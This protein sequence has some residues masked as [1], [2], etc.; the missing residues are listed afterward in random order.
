MDSLNP[1][2]RQ[3]VNA[4]EGPVL[5]LAG[6][7]TGK[8][9][10]VTCRIAHMIENGIQGRNLLAVTFTNK[11]ANEMRER[12][13]QMVDKKSARAM[14]ISTFHSLCTRILRED[15]GRLGYKENF[16]IYAGSDQ[17]GLLRQLIVRHGGRKEKLDPA[18]VLSVISASRN[19]GLGFDGIKDSL[20][21]NIAI[22]YQRELVAQNAVDFDDLLILA[23]KLLAENPDVRR[24]WQS[25]F[26][27]ITVD[28]FQDTNSLQMRLLKH[29]VGP[30]HN[31]CVVGDDDQSIYGWRG[32]QISNILDFESFFPN[33]TVIRLEENYRCTAPI[34]DVANALIRHNVGRREKTLHAHRGSGVPVRLISMP[35]DAEEAEFIIEDIESIRQKKNRNWEDFAILFRANAQSRILEQTLREH[36]IPYKM[37]GTKSFFDRRE[38]KDIIAYLGLIDNPQADLHLLRVLNTPPRGISDTTAR[39][40]IEWSR[41]HNQ[42]VWDALQDSNFLGSFSIRTQNSIRQFIQLIQ[43]YRQLFIASQQ[44]YSDLLEEFIEKTKYSDYMCRCCKTENE[45]QKRLISIG[46]IKADLH[47]YWEPG[48]QLTDFLSNLSL[49][50]DDDE[51]DDIESKPGVC[52]ITMHAS[53]G[54]EF[55]YVY[56]IGLEEG[57][58]PHKRSIEEGNFNEERRLLYVGIT[59]AQ[60]QLMMTFC[61]TRLRYGERTPCRRSSFLSEIPEDL[62]I[63]EAWDDIMQTP[64]TKEEESDFISSLRNM[65]LED[66][67]S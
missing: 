35:G 62:Y 19:T 39:L 57:I 26:Q 43:K 24:A 66:E 34:L 12:I 10:T 8:T 56:L 23:E 14:I 53:K 48:K 58:L 2:Q 21:R 30:K 20:I 67:T 40:A 52:L 64:I 1:A 6:A 51:R 59:R 63:Y 13:A 11:A 50:Q 38:V 55:P 17:M 9:R 5:I 16:T 28:E 31:I 15:I 37:V 60:E 18:Q 46:D 3:A 65:L 44:D 27:F 25:R 4:I 47:Q 7:G 32:A 22:S 49:D 41:E 36:K 33:P 54:L 29:L 61:S 42:S 45:Q